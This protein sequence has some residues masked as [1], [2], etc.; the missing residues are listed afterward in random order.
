M[1]MLSLAPDPAT[2]EARAADRLAAVS[3]CLALQGTPKSAGVLAA[4]VAP[5]ALGDPAAIV[6]G[7]ATLGIEAA[8]L[9]G[10]RLTS[11]MLPAVA[12]LADGSPAIVT[13]ID[14]AGAAIEAVDG[15]AARLDRETL[16]ETPVLLLRTAVARDTRAD[17]LVMETRRGWFWPTLWSYRR[18]FFEAAAL[19]AV[20]NLL[21]L[22]GIIFMMTVYDRIL[23]NQAYV[24]L[25]S[26]A[27]GVAIA[28]LFELLSRSLRSRVLDSAGKKIDLVL[29]DAIFG[30]VLGTRLE[31]RAASSGAFA[32]LLKEFESVRAFVTSASL[33]AIADLPFA[34]LFL[35]V[36]ALI[37]G[38][39]VWVPLAA[40]VVVLALS[41]IVQ[42]P[43]ARLA[44]EGLREGAV[45]HGTVVESLEALETLKALR[46]ESRMRRRHEAASAV[47][48][49][50]AVR[51]QTISNLALNLTMF[52]QQ[53]AGVVL[54][55]WGVYLAATGQV[56]AGAL[57]ASVQ[58]NS[59][60]LA[61]LASLSALAVRFQQA[62]SAL[63]SLNRIMALP[64]EREP[65]RD[66]LSGDHWRGDIEVRGLEFGYGEDAPAAIE[67]VSFR[68]RP[69]E[70]VAI[71]GR[72][73]S[74]KS[75]LLRLLA[76][77]Y[78]PRAGRIFLD[79]VELSAIEPADA[80]RT[81][82]LVGQDARLFHGTLRDNLR[83]AAPHAD[84]AEM[85]RVAAALGVAEIA[86]AHPLGFDRPV[87]E[88][89]DTL[90]GGQRQAVA[91]ARSLLAR[92]KMLLLDEPTS[93]M[94]Q[95]SEADAMKALSLLP[96]DTTI[97][98][99]THKQSVLPI[100]DR[101]IVMDRG[102]IVAD[103]PKSDIL[104][105]LSD[106]RVKAAA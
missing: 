11:D 43:L 49:T 92:P 61:P 83:A 13:A 22:A 84:D 58:L 100:I 28:M 85:V 99:V 19:S 3:R 75:T 25:W 91:L 65:D 37:A 90:S 31:H 66:Y 74:G 26:L 87:G 9:R 35:L 77:L 4:A 2:G 10:D 82:H 56:T 103:G 46:A 33:T 73:G 89:G 62:R 44:N 34:L 50:T 54:L 6:V 55:I 53:T 24:T 96:A 70:R 93:A 18:Y 21:G 81:V 51:S 80:R 72:M 23:P 106:G 68:I 27:A 78:R 79:G 41:V 59:R 29:G 88:R 12:E 104:A 69:G 52:V 36:T 94:D 98:L 102:R 30:R 76:A 5:E 95:R 39:L 47:I 71:L 38:P 48:A 8:W 63:Q 1:T 15:T 97:V 86:A 14:D 60:A 17:G 16:A 101:I 45:R 20:V 42:A 40:F 32:N 67:N 64:L 7:L 105:A 57:V